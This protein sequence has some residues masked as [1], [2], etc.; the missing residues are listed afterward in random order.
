MMA[1]G[2]TLVLVAALAGSALASGPAIPKGK[3]RTTGDLK[4][5]SKF[6]VAK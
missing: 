4:A 2:V 3:W 5:T 1:T 6:D